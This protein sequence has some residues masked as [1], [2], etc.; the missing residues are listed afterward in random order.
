MPF[1]KNKI[2]IDF[3][4]LN[5]WINARKITNYFLK[6]KHKKL[7]QKIKSKKNFIA[8]PTELEFINNDLLI[9]TEK[10][11]FKKNIPDYLFWSKNKIEKTK[12]PI[13]RDGMHFYEYR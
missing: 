2:I 5:H 11:I 6:K 1:S 13:M 8:T 7:S 4:K 12:R 3:L 9:P 10:I